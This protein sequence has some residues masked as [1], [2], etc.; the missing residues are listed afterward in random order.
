MD[1]DIQWE[2]AENYSRRFALKHFEIP[3][4]N[5][6]KLLRNNIF[7]YIRKRDLSL[8]YFEVSADNSTRY[9]FHCLAMMPKFHFC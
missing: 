2:R 4:S 6:L 3:D 7:E 1:I 9:C 8:D 5:R